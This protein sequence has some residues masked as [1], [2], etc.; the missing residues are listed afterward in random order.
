V[1]Q[2]VFE[3]QFVALLLELARG[4]AGGGG[5][6]GEGARAEAAASSESMTAKQVL[7]PQPLSLHAVVL[8]HLVLLLNPEFYP[9]L[10]PVVLRAV[11]R[12][13]RWRR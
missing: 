1:F 11:A 4:A 8:F 5:G 3:Q 9:G 2:V 13:F 6:G 12:V 7:T 10:P